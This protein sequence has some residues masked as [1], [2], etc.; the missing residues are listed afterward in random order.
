MD[1][2]G[3][4]KQ[5]SGAFQRRFDEIEAVHNFDY[6]PEFEIAIAETLQR[7]VP[8]R[9]GICRGFV[10]SKDGHCQG[11]DIILFDQHKFP[12]LRFLSD[13]LRTKQKVPAEA[14]LAY[15]E[16]KHS[17]FL[18][19]S[20]SGQ[21]LQHAVTQADRVKRQ[22][23]PAIPL[24]NLE[25]AGVNLGEGFT[26]VPKPG[27]PSIWNPYY[28][29]IIA[30]NVYYSARDRSTPNVIELAKALEKFD[31]GVLPD[32]MVA[33][34]LVAVPG[35]S[36]TPSEPH[37]L[38]P[39]YIAGNDLLLKHSDNSMGVAIAHL[40]WACGHIRLGNIDWPQMFGAMFSGTVVC[41]TN[42]R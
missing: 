20:D 30:R 34:G 29:M 31:P 32:C 1:Y 12:A 7:L 37:E 21:S 11:D 13:N 26:V 27:L 17:L 39:F 18:D 14:V 2:G 10:V 3:W 9:I 6:G 23:R 40:L 41:L 22:V 15:I 33:G 4:L 35:L 8:S 19:E 5:L 24:T 25:D 16:A 42:H 28:T 38:R 36:T